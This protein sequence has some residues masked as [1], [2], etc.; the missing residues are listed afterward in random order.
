MVVKFP[1][2]HTEVRYATL[3]MAPPDMISREQAI[4]MG[5]PESR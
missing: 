3:R 1:D 5:A 4:I 2:G